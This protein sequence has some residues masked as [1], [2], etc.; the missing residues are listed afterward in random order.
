M[1]RGMSSTSPRSRTV[2]LVLAV[3]FFFF[4]LGGLHRLYVGKIGTF[5]LQL[6]TLGGLGIWQI[7]DIVRI[8]LG[9]FTDAQERDIC[10][11]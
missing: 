11:W 3:T 1:M 8:L 5:I 2:T 6:V 4:G 9:S 7:I 10:E